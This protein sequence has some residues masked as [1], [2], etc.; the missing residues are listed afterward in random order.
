MV[1]LVGLLDTTSCRGTS[2]LARVDHAHVR[3][4]WNTL[5]SVNKCKLMIVIK[6]KW[7]NINRLNEQTFTDINE[8]TIHVF[9]FDS[10]TKRTKKN[11][12]LLVYWINDILWNDSH[13]DVYMRCGSSRQINIRDIHKEHKLWWVLSFKLYVRKNSK[14][15][16]YQNFIY[17]VKR[18][19]DMYIYK[20]ET[21]IPRSPSAMSCGGVVWAPSFPRGQQGGGTPYF[22]TFYLKATQPNC[23]QP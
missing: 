5:A 13:L 7:T 9:T 4:T 3:C 16:C 15:I 1:E 8:W 22:C 17:I 11:P 6:R 19:F 14:Y 12:C 20:W 2:R 23:A 21:M 18:V 10:L